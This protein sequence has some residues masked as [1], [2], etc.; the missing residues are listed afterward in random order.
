MQTARGALVAL[1]DRRIVLAAGFAKP[2]KRNQAEDAERRRR[3]HKG[4]CQCAAEVRTA[5][6]R[7]RKTRRE[8]EVRVPEHVVC[9]FGRQVRGAAAGG[10]RGGARDVVDD[11]W[12]GMGRRC[13][14]GAGTLWRRREECAVRAVCVEGADEERETDRKADGD[15]ECE[16]CCAKA[17][18]P[19]DHGSAVVGG[20]TTVASRLCGGGGG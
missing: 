15:D 10:G 17:K 2:P 20:F 8:R 4:E 16:A 14:A 6:G 13:V 7:W 11:V 3:N 5:A 1:H 9:V 19:R 12:E 18:Y